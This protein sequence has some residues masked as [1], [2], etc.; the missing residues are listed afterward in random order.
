MGKI[1]EK[2][3]DGV[4]KVVPGSG[5]GRIKRMLDLEDQIYVPKKIVAAEAIEEE[6]EK[7]DS[8]ET[9][10]TE[11]LSRAAELLKI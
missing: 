1:L 6:T 3:K 2:M 10:E 9:E 11:E 8:V 4:Y 7:S 5:T